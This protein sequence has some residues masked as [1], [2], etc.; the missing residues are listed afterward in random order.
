[1]FTKSTPHPLKPINPFL[2]HQSALTRAITPVVDNG[3]YVDF[4]THIHILDTFADFFDDA[5]EFMS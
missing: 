1:V 2:S 5:A 4:I 3:L